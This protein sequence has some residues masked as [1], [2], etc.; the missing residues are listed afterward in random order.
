MVLIAFISSFE[1][2]RQHNKQMYDTVFSPVF[3]KCIHVDQEALIWFSFITIFVRVSM[4]WSPFLVYQRP[5]VEVISA[6]H[7]DSR[8]LQENWEI[9]YHITS[10]IRSWPYIRYLTFSINA[11]ISTN[12]GLL[13]HTYVPIRCFWCIYKYVP[14]RGYWYIY[15]VHYPIIL[16]PWNSIY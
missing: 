8:D 7:I 3:S 16:L 5:A 14:I 10:P 6:D 12:K 13:V 2:F 4:D 9:C 1:T 15:Y 11:Y